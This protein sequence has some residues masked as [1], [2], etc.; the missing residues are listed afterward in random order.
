[1]TESEWAKNIV[2]QARKIANRYAQGPTANKECVND[3][4]DLIK[5]KEETI[6]SHD[7]PAPTV[8]S[9][10]EEAY[11]ANGFVKCP[12]CQLWL[13]PDKLKQL[14]CSLHTTEAIPPLSSYAKTD[15][16]A[17][18]LWPADK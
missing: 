11:K 12:H 10:D 16:R 7:S 9:E 4:L 6:P 5:W 8:T 15:C 2:M 1:M 14:P 18:N 13:E 17:G 3:I